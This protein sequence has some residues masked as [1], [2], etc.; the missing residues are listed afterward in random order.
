[1]TIVRL[2]MSGIKISQGPRRIAQIKEPFASNYISHRAILVAS[3]SWN[4]F[5]S[6]SP[7]KVWIND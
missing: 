7:S 5:E 6:F 3:F 4:G 1:M 2:D